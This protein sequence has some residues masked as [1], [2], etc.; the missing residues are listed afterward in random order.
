MMLNYNYLIEYPG[1]IAGLKIGIILLQ[2]APRFSKKLAA[3]G[4]AK[5]SKKESK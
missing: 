1:L 5:N 2:T 3:D 4:L